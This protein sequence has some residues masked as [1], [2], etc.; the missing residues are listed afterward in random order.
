MASVNQMQMSPYDG[1]KFIFMSSA[2]AFNPRSN[3]SSAQKRHG[4]KSLY[5]VVVAS[6]PSIAHIYYTGLAETV[7]EISDPYDAVFRLSEW[8][9]TIL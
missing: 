8:L 9:R 3:C 5:L 2:N 4:I 7:L 1:K 6:L